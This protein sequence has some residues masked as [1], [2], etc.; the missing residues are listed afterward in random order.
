[1]F[2]D[3]GRL[4]KKKHVFHP[5][6]FVQKKL[7]SGS[8][9]VPK[10][11]DERTTGDH[12]LDYSPFFLNIKKIEPSGSLWILWRL[13]SKSRRH[14]FHPV[15]KSVFFVTRV[16]EKKSTPKLGRWM[17]KATSSCGSPQQNFSIKCLS[18]Q[19]LCFAA[20]TNKGRLKHLNCNVFGVFFNWMDRSGGEAYSV[21]LNYQ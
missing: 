1:M 11:S 12:S 10:E 13:A 21:P 6:I 15:W 16:S 14:F 17:A 4:G 18:Q 2:S 3:L 19:V 7:P 5:V 9:D 20:K 8:G